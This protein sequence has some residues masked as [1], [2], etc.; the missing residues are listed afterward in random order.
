MVSFTILKYCLNTEIKIIQIKH[1][2]FK[3]YKSSPC[4]LYS[5]PV[6]STQ[7]VF[8]FVF[9]EVGIFPNTYRDIKKCV[10]LSYSLLS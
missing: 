2:K 5:I 1:E 6:Y 8:S 7:V 10:V 4:P 3:Q 9:R